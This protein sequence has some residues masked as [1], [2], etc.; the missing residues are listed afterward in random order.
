MVLGLLP[1]VELVRTAR[2][3]REA[4]ALTGERSPKSS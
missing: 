4:V 2:D 3:V 1:G